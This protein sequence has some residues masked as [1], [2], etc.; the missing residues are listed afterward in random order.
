MEVQKVYLGF[1]RYRLQRTFSYAVRENIVQNL[2]HASI[3][4][5]FDPDADFDLALFA[6]SEDML[7]QL[8]KIKGKRVRKCLLAGF[9]VDDFNDDPTANKFLSDISINSANQADFLLTFFESQMRALLRMGIRKEIRLFPP[10]PTFHGDDI[11]QAERDAFR[12]YY[13]IPKDKKVIVSFGFRRD[14][15]SIA[16][17]DSLSR[18]FPNCEFL[19]F[20][21]QEKEFLRQKMQERLSHQTN[22]RYVSTLP[23]ELYHSAL[24][25]V[26]AVFFPQVFLTYPTIILDFIAHEVPLV[27]YR[28]IDLPEL[29]N[30]KTALLPKD[31]NELYQALRHI[32]EENKA[33]SAKAHLLPYML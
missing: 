22:I 28:A 16:I 8:P 15:E 1:D 30:E 26:D 7:S 5:T 27:A 17:L 12:S 14:M 3:A 13:R 9:D 18:V 10:R 2:R 23:E 31:F 32:Q 29:V 20:G 33:K 25:S 4:Y 19:Y 11:L 6:S 24:V 21:E